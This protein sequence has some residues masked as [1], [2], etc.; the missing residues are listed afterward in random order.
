MITGGTHNT[1]ASGR[2][3]WTFLP[4][5]RKTVLSKTE[6]WNEA[7][8]QSKDSPLSQTLKSKAALTRLSVAGG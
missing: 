6:L 4:M 2:D 7:Q 8:R 3:W 5:Q 1:T